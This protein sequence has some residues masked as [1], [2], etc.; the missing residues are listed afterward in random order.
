VSFELVPLL[1]PLAAGAAPPLLAA[2]AAAAFAA[3]LS[4]NCFNKF[5]D[6]STL[7]V[8]PFTVEL[9]NAATAWN[10]DSIPALSHVK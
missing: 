4:L 6:N 2:A 9:S 10:A 5:F 3:C 7:N 8:I 1:V